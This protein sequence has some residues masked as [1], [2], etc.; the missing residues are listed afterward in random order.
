MITR[1]SCPV[2]IRNFIIKCFMHHIQACL[3]DIFGRV[4]QLG[5][6]HQFLDI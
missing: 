4:V 6:M 5:L 2:H 1:I 3:K